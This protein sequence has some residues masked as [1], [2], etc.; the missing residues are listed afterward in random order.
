MYDVG[1]VA[2]CFYDAMPI[3]AKLGFSGFVQVLVQPTILQTVDVPIPSRMGYV[4][5]PRG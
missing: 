4:C 3:N 5:A 2:R 1:S